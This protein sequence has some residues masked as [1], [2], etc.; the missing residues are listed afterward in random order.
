MGYKGKFITFEGI[1]GSGKTTQSEL[2]LNYLER[3]GLD[4]TWTREP[5][6]TELGREL[7]EI[8]LVRK[9]TLS[10]MA[11]LLIFAADRTQH[12]SDVIRP[13]L[14]SGEIVLCDRYID[15][16]LAY[17]GYGRG[18][19]IKEIL[20]INEMAT[21]G[22]K[23]DLTL[24]YDI[25]YEVT[26]RVRNKDRIESSG[27]EFFKRTRN[28]FLIIAKEEPERV[29]VIDRYPSR[30]PEKSIKQTFEHGTR[31]LIDKLLRI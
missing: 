14:E 17:Q 13:A 25:P 28:G 9:G 22:L 7:R 18:L 6:G 8:L 19:H 11:E 21:L 24:V 31:P 12:T 4:V 27:D 5:G 2:T 3:L 1:D 20:V 23:P 15:S 10:D 16:T 30:S 26:N 29:K